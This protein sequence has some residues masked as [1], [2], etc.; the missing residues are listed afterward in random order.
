MKKTLTICALAGAVA[1]SGC[2]T[3]GN[4]KLDNI[5]AQ[6]QSAAVNLC[7][8]EPTIA[9]VLAIVNAQAGAT[10]DGIAKQVCAA[11]QVPTAAF[12]LR[13]A[14]AKPSRVVTVGRKRITVR[15]HFV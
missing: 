4:N 11:V 7:R 14:G 2:V 13:A 3:T 1:L 12:S 6:I 15:G 10:I 8:F 5:V 9:T